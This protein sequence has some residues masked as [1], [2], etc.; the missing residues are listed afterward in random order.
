[1]WSPIITHQKPSITGM[2]CTETF[3]FSTGTFLKFANFFFL[4][5]YSFAIIKSY[6]YVILF[7]KVVVMFVFVFLVLTVLWL[8]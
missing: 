3:L 6:R 7:G 5:Q 1:M 4:S 2:H 8:V